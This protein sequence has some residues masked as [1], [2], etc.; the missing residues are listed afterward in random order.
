MTAQAG[1]RYPAVLPPILRP[2]VAVRS[3][4][5]RAAALALPAGI[6]GF[7]FLGPLVWT[8]DPAA[9]D[10]ATVLRGPSWLHPAGT[11]GLG[12]DQLARLMQGGAATLL[13]AGPGAALAF[14]FGTAY[15]VASGLSPRW[16][17][18]ALMRVLDA[19]LALPALVV[20]IALGALMDLNEG[21]LILLLGAVAWAPLARLVRNEAVAIRGRDF[22]QASQQ[23][24]GG[25][26]HLAR[27]HLLPVMQ[28]VLLVNFTLLV[29][30][31]IALISALG[32]LGLGVQPP[33]T[34]WGQ[35]LQEGLMLVD[36]HPWWLV[37]PPGLL[38]AASLLATSLAGGALLPPRRPR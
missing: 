31:C 36:L 14:G 32:F 17:D 2:R 12:R 21:A 20:V 15:G 22:I 18:A 37:A 33:R 9:I 16:L 3:G 10:P 26:W 19:I 8:H 25:F 38:I 4:L 23:M 34:S 29:G 1:A 6:V 27:V 30:D 28:S 13:V 11:D 35:L 7:C 5:A 24:G